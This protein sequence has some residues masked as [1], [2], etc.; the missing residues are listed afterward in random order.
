MDIGNANS[1]ASLR[2]FVCVLCAK[3]LLQSD[4]SDSLS[5]SLS[6]LDHRIGDTSFRNIPFGFY[7]GDGYFQMLLVDPFL[8]DFRWI[9]VASR[10]SLQSIRYSRV[11]PLWV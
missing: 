1:N 2:K 8:R 6:S 9:S 5:L 10:T 7:L 4:K 11:N 3:I